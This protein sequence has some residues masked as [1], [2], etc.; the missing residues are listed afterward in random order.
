MVTFDQWMKMNQRMWEQFNITNKFIEQHN[1][2]YRFTE[3]LL[4]YASSIG[5]ASHP[6]DSFESRDK[7]NRLAIGTLPPFIFFLALVYLTKNKKDYKKSYQ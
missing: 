3:P 6:I 2:S 5:A 1:A 4:D 7:I